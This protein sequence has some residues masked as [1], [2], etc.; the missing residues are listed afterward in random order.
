M[1]FYWYVVHVYLLSFRFCSILC[2]FLVFLEKPLKRRSLVTVYSLHSIKTV[3]SSSLLFPKDF[4][5]TLEHPLLLFYFS[6][7]LPPNDAP[8]YY[9][10]FFSTKCVSRQTF[11]YYPSWIISQLL[12]QCGHSFLHY[13]RRCK[14]EFNFNWHQESIFTLLSVLKS[15]FLCKFYQ[16]CN[17]YT[18]FFLQKWYIPY[19]LLC[20]A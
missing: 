6:W 18:G 19:P 14:I 12:Q 5:L 10:F 15:C 7:R 1:Y 2:F 3:L 20:L 17:T 9:Y 13:W 8:L 11:S 16:L 4:C